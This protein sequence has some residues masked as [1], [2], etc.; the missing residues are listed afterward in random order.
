MLGFDEALVPALYRIRRIR[1]MHVKRRGVLNPSKAKPKV[2]NLFHQTLY[3]I[4]R[5]AKQ[6]ISSSSRSKEWP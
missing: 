3:F 4:S 6:S 1:L 2:S 5:L